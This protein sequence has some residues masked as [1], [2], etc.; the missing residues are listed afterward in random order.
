M[1]FELTLY[2]WYPAAPTPALRRRIVFLIG[3]M[4]TSALRKRPVLYITP[5]K[6]TNNNTRQMAKTKIKLDCICRLRQ[7]V[8]GTLYLFI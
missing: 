8:N 7:N 1:N 2:C 5:T 4:M 3:A 6:I